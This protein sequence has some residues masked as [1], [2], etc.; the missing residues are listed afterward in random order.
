M[1]HELQLC[2]EIDFTENFLLVAPLRFRSSSTTSRKLNK[3]Q[4]F[5]TRPKH[6]KLT[7]T[8]DKKPN[9]DICILHNIIHHLKE[10][11]SKTKQLLNIFDK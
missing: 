9:S 5:S 3:F 4:K 7:F 1:T 11:W 10:L 6:I 8:L 2:L